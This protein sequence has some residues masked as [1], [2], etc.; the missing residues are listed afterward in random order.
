M[1]M[2]D[3]ATP[4]ARLAAFFL[5]RSWVFMGPC[6]LAACTS[7]SPPAEDAAAELGGAVEAEGASLRAGELIA[8]EWGTFTSMQGSQGTILDGLHHESERLPAFVHSNLGAS[9]VSPFV[10][11]GDQSLGAPV[12]RVNSKMET[13]VIYFYTKTRRRVSVNVD[14]TSGLLTQWYPH[15]AQAPDSTG[16]RVGNPGSAS[17]GRAHAGVIDVSGIERSSLGWELDLTPFGEAAPAGIPAVEAHDPWQYAREVRAAYVVSHGA[18]GPEADHYVFYRGLGRMTPTIDVQALANGFV[19]VRNTGAQAITGAFVLEMGAS[20]GRFQK[21]VDLGAGASRPVALGQAP[22]A[23]RER[24]VAELSAEVQKSLVAQGLFEDEAIAMVRTWA[25][26]WFA[27]EGTRVISFVPR[28][29][30]DAVLPL[31]ITPV[32]DALVRVLVARHEYLTPETEADVVAALRDRMSSE[33][34]KRDAAM[35]RLG[36]LG[37]F[38]EPAVRR[39][40]TSS[41]DAAVKQSATELLGSYR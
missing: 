18:K 21:I 32:P 24:V 8:H 6:A 29:V 5:R 35:R 27:S 1:T 10:S 30:T 41:G 9:Q 23:D 20:S 33:P 17:P 38:L 34:T 7:A 31:R 22:L 12:H 36:R 26:T 14:F 28:Q 19:V 37:R 25:P 39:A 40:V 4:G 3:S 15:A 11:Y 13:P 2:F 16:A